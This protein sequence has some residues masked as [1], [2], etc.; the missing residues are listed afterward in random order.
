M[1]LAECFGY[2]VRAKP[3]DEVH[4]SYSL[5]VTLTFHSCPHVL[6]RY[7]VSEASGSPFSGTAATFF[8]LLNA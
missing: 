8:R 4:G 3:S 5:L 1:V 6:Q 2:L 7:F